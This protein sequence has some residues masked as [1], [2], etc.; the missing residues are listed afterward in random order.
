[1][2]IIRKYFFINQKYLAAPCKDLLGAKMCKVLIDL[3]EC[4]GPKVSENCEKS[5]EICVDRKYNNSSLLLPFSI[6]LG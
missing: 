6:I 3:Y 2:F 4:D 5:C 1:M